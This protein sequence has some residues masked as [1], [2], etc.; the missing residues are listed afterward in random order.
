MLK[1][2]FPALALVL[3]SLA[4]PR[5]AGAFD[6]L[7]HSYFTD[8]ACLR[9][10]RLLGERLTRGA[11]TDD[12]R[13]RYLAL[14]LLC[15]AR[16]DT[17]YCGADETKRATAAIN[18]LPP[19][20]SNA[21]TFGDFS[22]LADHVSRFGPVRG[23][24]GPADDQDG[25]ATTVFTYMAE[26]TETV[27][28]VIGDVADNACEST[29]VPWSRVETDVTRFETA[30]AS[31]G[32]LPDVPVRF[33]SPLNRGE[34]TRGPYDPAGV[35]SFDNPHFLDMV[36]ND[37]NHFAG[38][39][40]SGWLGF[41]STAVDIVGRPCAEVVG[42]DAGTLEDLAA[43][44]PAFEAL[45]W[46]ELPDPELRSKACALLADIVAGRLRLW[47]GMAEPWLTAPVAAQLAAPGPALLEKTAVAVLALVF[48]GDGLHFLQDSVS[49]GHLR[50]ADGLRALEDR[51]YGH[52]FDNRHGL[53]AVTP[54]RDGEHRYVAYGDAYLLGEP[55]GAGCDGAPAAVTRP[56][57]VADCLVAH[58]RG[59]LVATST[60]SILDWA[61]GGPM[62]ADAAT[63]NAEPLQALVAS[64]LP[65]APTHA[66]GFD[67]SPGERHL[68]PVALPVP[69]PP[70]TY[71]TLALST[72][73]DG[74]GRGTQFGLDTSFYSALGRDAGWLT[75]YRVGIRMDD[76]AE[77]QFSGDFA[78]GFH[79]RW[80]ARFL[81]D[82]EPFVYAGIKGDRPDRMFVAGL[83][84]RLGLTVLP[85]GWIKLPLELNVSYRL[86]LRLVTSEY[87]F[88]GKSLDLEAH[89]ILFSLGLA[90]M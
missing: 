48:E 35:Y 22:S 87:G 45:A 44:R 74:A 79:F 84:P 78:Y 66:P 41:H 10:Q 86:P 71:Q 81:L 42:F 65:M 59:L 32:K 43:D 57:D 50:T 82:M 12:D 51:R 1:Y 76:A 83:G 69:P 6:Y 29:P 46:G 70:Y 62:F 31:E 16:W 33:F 80:A 27:G 18:R 85:E 73:V 7:E 15:P 24:P 11:A 60:A 3:A 75:N 53:T 61:L 68:T 36:L 23:L 14:G 55:G 40:Y 77:R 25:L 52:D 28:G 17:P 38:R 37:R 39:A 21:L 19:G 4:F 54:L 2:R 20:G 88:F 63:A 30:L 47:Q 58:Q 9:A 56:A 90:Y 34:V 64:A 89:W 67:R 26:A 8:R 72:A 13:A 5:N 49:A